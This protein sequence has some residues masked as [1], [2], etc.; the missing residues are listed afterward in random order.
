MTTTAQNNEQHI[1][2]AN[3][4]LWLKLKKEEIEVKKRIKDVENKLREYASA[5]R[6]AFSNK[7]TMRVGNSKLIFYKGGK[8]ITGD[9]FDLSEF[10]NEYP[11]CIE[12]T[13]KLS[14]LKDFIV[15]DKIAKEIE[16]QFSLT[17]KQEEC[18]KIE[19]A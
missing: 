5:N 17:I 2:E 16:D 11:E 10:A 15:S 14:K 7:S 3:A 18:F 9:K 1:A 4:A 8:I 12:F 6:A 19:K 13:V